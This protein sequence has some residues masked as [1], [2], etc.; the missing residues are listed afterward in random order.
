MVIKEFKVQYI[1][2]YIYTIQIQIYILNFGWTL[3]LEI[4]FYYNKLLFIKI[5]N[6]DIVHT[7]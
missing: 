7:L 6:G 5:K 4:R 2:I 3:I 1:Y